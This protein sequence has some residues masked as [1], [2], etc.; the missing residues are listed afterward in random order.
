MFLNITGFLVSAPQMIWSET[1]HMPILI[2][3][4]HPT[5]IT[6]DGCQLKMNHTSKSMEKLSTALNSG[7]FLPY[8]TTGKWHRELGKGWH[9]RN[10]YKS[11]P[12]VKFTFSTDK[13]RASIENIHTIPYINPAI[14]QTSTSVMVPQ[15]QKCKSIWDIKKWK[16]PTPSKGIITFSTSVGTIDNI[17][18]SI[19]PPS[20]YKPGMDENKKPSPPL[21]QIVI[22]NNNNAY[23]FIRKKSNGPRASSFIKKKLIDPSQEQNWWIILNNDII[24]IGSGIAPGEN[25]FLRYQDKHPLHASYVGFSNDG[26]SIHYKNIKIAPISKELES[27]QAL[28]FVNK[29]IWKSKDGKKNVSLTLG[30]YPELEIDG[31]ILQ[32]KP[33]KVTSYNFNPVHMRSHHSGWGFSMRRTGNDDYP[34]AESNTRSGTWNKD[35]GNGLKVLHLFRKF[36]PQKNVTIQP[37][38]SRHIR[39]KKK[40]IKNIYRYFVSIIDLDRNEYNFEVTTTSQEKENNAIK[41]RLINLTK[42]VDAFFKKSLLEPANITDSQKQQHLAITKKEIDLTHA[43]LA[44][45]EPGTLKLANKAINKAYETVIQALDDIPNPIKPTIANTTQ[46]GNQIY[47]IKEGKDHSPIKYGNAWSI[48]GQGT[49]VFDVNKGCSNLTVNFD[50]GTF[51]SLGF[52]TGGTSTV[53]LSVNKKWITP[54]KPILSP[55]GDL[56]FSVIGEVPGNYKIDFDFYKGTMSLTRKNNDGS[57]PQTLEWESADLKTISPCHYL[58]KIENKTKNKIINNLATKIKTSTE[59]YPLPTKNINLSFTPVISMSLGLPSFLEIN[60][61]KIP[62]QKESITLKEFKE[63]HGIEMLTNLPSFPEPTPLEHFWNMQTIF[64]GIGSDGQSYYYIQLQG[65]SE[66]LYGFSGNNLSLHQAKIHIDKMEFLKQQMNIIISP[67]QISAIN[68]INKNIG[69]LSK[70]TE[71]TVASHNFKTTYNNSVLALSKI[72]KIFKDIGKYHY[73]T[74]KDLNN[75]KNQIKEKA[76]QINTWVNKAKNDQHKVKV[77]NLTLI[78]KKPEYK[79]AS[80][81]LE[82]AE[83]GNALIDHALKSDDYYEVLFA[84]KQISKTYSLSQKAQKTLKDLT[85]TITEKNVGHLEEQ[86]EESDIMKDL[87]LQIKKK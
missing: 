87:Q 34:E 14:Q 29:E 77:H 84:S 26:P 23:S 42:Y 1:N 49:I 54:K 67:K 3:H 53:G 8:P 44:A 4:T 12:K 9:L 51:I 11:S 62:L 45:N 66:H 21:Y 65:P 27:H 19:A 10:I 71:Q 28:P 38:F 48:S 43:L 17:V 56:R 68:E 83:A 75:L 60:N 24:R 72:K 2:E 85:K 41:N 61:R 30:R 47:Y 55:K 70:A 33:S 25:E 46:P 79:D 36:I 64:H 32:L 20:S 86:S 58:V 59:V 50:T 63:K 57:K 76:K 40:P 7:P 52:K 22:G 74:S 73:P 16:L 37:L 80:I 39:K 81:K 18:V 69:S 31:K 6:I 15:N 13:E 35:L 82:Q 78:M 5:K